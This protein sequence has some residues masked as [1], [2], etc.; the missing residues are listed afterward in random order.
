MNCTDWFTTR[1]F[2][3]NRSINV[4][5]EGRTS[6][7]RPRGYQR[8][9]VVESA[10]N[11]FWAHGYEGTS[12]VE[13][14]RSTGLNRS[15]LYLAFGGK[16]SL[17]DAAFD[18]Y[19]ETFIDPLI[20]TMEGGSAELAEIATFLSEIRAYLLEVPT[21]SQRGC[22]MVNA[23]AEL[24]GRDQDATD[25]GIA[26]RDRLRRA[27]THALEG[28]AANGN[29]APMAIRR[30]AWMLASATFGVWLT[31]RIDPLDAA[32]LC[33]TIA[34]EVISWGSTPSEV[35]PRRL[36]DAPSAPGRDDAGL[37]SVEPDLGEP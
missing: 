34:A 6:V 35:S 16:R 18:D 22:L 26:Y 14:E 27:F 19:T 5:P 37:D 12:I 7:P 3:T 24:S 17:F 28:A 30:R 20:A 15:S 25:R 36:P 33:E 21:L 8:A 2:C 9:K 1:R 29:G 10:K 32:A 4:N 11:S 23:I 13:L 31:A